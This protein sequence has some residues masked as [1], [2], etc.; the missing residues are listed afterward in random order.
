MRQRQGGFGSIGRRRLGLS[1]GFRYCQRWSEFVEAL[2]KTGDILKSTKSVGSNSGSGR[3][4]S[5]IFCV[6]VS[7][8][9]L[10]CVVEFL[11]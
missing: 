9:V 4:A 10:T 6:N 7:S 5:V 11:Q 1:L 3:G 8:S 2:L